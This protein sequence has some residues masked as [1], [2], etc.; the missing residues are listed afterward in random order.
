MPAALI[1]QLIIA[2]GPSAIGLIDTLIAK[3]SANGTVSADEWAT[4][5]ASLKLSAND[6]MKAQLTAA[7]ID[8]TS[9]NAVALLALTK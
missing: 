8:L 5:S 9:P 6:H 1:A 3:W 7:G 2:L 4:L